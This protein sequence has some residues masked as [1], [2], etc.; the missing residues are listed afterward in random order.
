[1]TDEPFVES[2]PSAPRTASRDSDPAPALD[3]HASAALDRLTRWAAKALR[4]SAAVVTLADEERTVVASAT[5]ELAARESPRLRE[6]ARQILRTGQ[7]RATGDA[8]TER[9]RDELDGEGV[10]FLGA[11]L[12]DASGDA[13]GSFCVVDSRARRWTIQDVELVTELTSSAMTELDLQAARAEAEREKRWTDRQQ[14]VLELIAARAPLSRTLSELL[15]A[16]ETHAPGMLAAIA[17]LER[18]R[19]GP[20]QLRVA[21]GLGLPRGFT[22]ALDGVAV[23]EGASISAT[24]AYRRE[25]LAVRNVTQAGLQPWYV[26]LA[27]RHGLRAGW[28]TPI[29]SRGGAVL[30]TFTIYSRETRSP[31]TNDR[32]V[33]DRSVHLAR[34]AIEQADGADALRRTATRAQSLAREQ[35]ALQRV[36]T[37]VAG[38]TDPEILF[39]LVAEQVGRLLKADA[40]YVLRFEDEDQYRVMGAW[41]REEERMLALDAL[42]RHLPDG[43]CA[44]LRK[45]RTARRCTVEAGHD[46]L[47]FRQRIAAPVIVDGRSWGIVVA[48]HDTVG[49]RREDEKRLVR[50]A[51]LASVAV[52]N[53][54]AHEALA[55]QARTDSLTGLANRRT[56]DERLAEET[57]RANRHTRALSVMLV[58]VDHFK[59][60]NDRFG[61][62]TGDRV[63]VNLAESL[64]SVM[65]SGDLLA[66]IGGDEMAMILPDCRTE[67]AALVAR[68]MLAAIGA[69]SSLARRHG[70]TLSAGVAGLVAGQSADDLLRC[71]D[72]ALYAAKDDGRNQVAVYEADMPDRDH[73]RLSA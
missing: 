5:G 64:R 23:A 27:T 16:A 35:T 65:R 63:L 46:A 72:Q 53:A 34:L 47:G 4:A 36:A 56:F 15:H 73:L 2:D 11:P 59:T 71:A 55:T 61:H 10:A 31:D 19:G 51:Q 26:D 32:V 7:P 8:R 40:G 42:A 38:E 9:W 48:L 60:I 43:I 45:G 14:A 24:A 54:R 39:S 52:A 49:F 66:R 29:L 69:D 58:D 62:A 41:A 3:V 6:F 70:V 68:R 57:E 50:F 20:D 30:G 13:V 25:P 28:S 12:L 17:R 1:V 37:R 18:V 67:Q 22:S 33:I 21:A 44:A